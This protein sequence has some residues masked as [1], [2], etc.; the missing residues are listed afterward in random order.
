MHFIR[1]LYVVNPGSIRGNSASINC[2]QLV[3]GGKMANNYVPYHTDDEQNEG[4]ALSNLGLRTVD[5]KKGGL[6][7]RSNS[8]DGSLAWTDTTWHNWKTVGRGGTTT[9]PGFH[10]DQHLTIDSNCQC[11][12]GGPFFLLER[13]G[14]RVEIKP[15][16]T[17]SSP[18]ISSCCSVGVCLALMFPSHYAFME[19][20]KFINL[21]STMIIS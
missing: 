5:S 18:I 15:E 12:G 8:G 10:S 11:W 6:V 16:T 19:N 20:F 21:H 14:Q 9:H 4:R 17:N 3:R 1:V 2:S 13:S 7:L